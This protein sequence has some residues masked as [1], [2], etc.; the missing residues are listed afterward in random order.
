MSLAGPAARARD[1]TRTL[2]CESLTLTVAEPETSQAPSVSFL[3]HPSST[4]VSPAG[5]AARASLL[6]T[7]LAR[8]RP[9][10]RLEFQWV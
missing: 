5:F 6:S 2:S 7:A 4:R 1:L 9:A 10:Y 8:R 3:S